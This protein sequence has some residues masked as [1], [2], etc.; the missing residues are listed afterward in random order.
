MPLKCPVPR[1]VPRVRSHQ[2]GGVVAGPLSQ[3]SVGIF[4]SGVLCLLLLPRT[5]H[6]HAHLIRLGCH[7]SIYF[8]WTVIEG[9]RVEA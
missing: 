3:V 9:L 5:P 8:P 6:G 4:Y 7:L 1:S 2:H